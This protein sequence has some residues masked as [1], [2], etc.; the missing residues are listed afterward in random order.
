MRFWLVL[1][2]LVFSAA[3]AGAAEVIESRFQVE[4][5]EGDELVVSQQP[6]VPLLADVAC[7]NW[8][9]RFAPRTGE[10][11]FVERLVL[12]GLAASWDPEDGDTTTEIV[13]DP[14]GLGVTSSFTTAPDAEGWVTG[15]WCVAEGDPLG[16]HVIS[17]EV[18]GAPVGSWPF[19]VVPAADYVAPADAAPEATAAAPSDRSGG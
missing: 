5:T 14:D 17:V 18:D 13:V 16:E 15:G 8:Y 3:H 6:V 2:G 9:V 19:K 1:S 10:L 11:A 7:Y 12:P 4:I